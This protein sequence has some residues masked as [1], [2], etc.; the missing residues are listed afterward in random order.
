MEPTRNSTITQSLLGTEFLETLHRNCL[1][2]KVGEELLTVS[3]SPAYF[4]TILYATLPS[5][6]E[7]LYLGRA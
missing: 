1:Y 5:I 4:Y 7:V 2:L 3:C 6:I